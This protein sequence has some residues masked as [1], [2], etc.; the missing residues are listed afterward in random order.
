MPLTVAIK[1]DRLAEAFGLQLTLGLR[2]GEVL[3]L[4]WSDIDLGDAPTVHVRQQLQRRDGEG[5]V[6]VEFKTQQSRR[7][8]ALT[9]QMETA[10][11]S[12]RAV[13]AAERLQAG[14]SWHDGGGLVFTTPSGRRSTPTTTGTGS[15]RSPSAAASG[16]GRRMSSAT[17]PARC[18]SRPASR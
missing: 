13:Q 9:A 7:D 14:A 3:G 17:P 2:R 16:T 11:R 10:L 8:L 6:L 4:R 18:C 15:A 1:G 5:L 12:W